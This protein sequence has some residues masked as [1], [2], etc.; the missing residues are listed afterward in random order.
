MSTWS[1]R[2]LA[3][4]SLVDLIE[5][6]SNS[7]RVLPASKSRHAILFGRPLFFPLS[8]TF[9]LE[10]HWLESAAPQWRPVI[11]PRRARFSSHKCKE[12][13]WAGQFCGPERVKPIGSAGMLP[14]KPLGP[15]QWSSGFCERN[16]AHEAWALEK[17]PTNR[18]QKLSRL[19]FYSIRLA[20][21]DQDESSHCFPATSV[22]GQP[23]SSPVAEPLGKCI[24]I[25]FK[26]EKN[27]KTKSN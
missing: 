1:T 16:C 19:F 7:S 4:I 5:I 14:L 8:I 2:N 17:C 13:Q 23:L 11:G 25:V 12:I 10:E 6:N 18:P 9:R 20:S 26:L 15:K 21:G 22:L 27:R 24:L 3:R